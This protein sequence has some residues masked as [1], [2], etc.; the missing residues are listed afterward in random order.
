MIRYSRVSV[1]GWG[2]VVLPLISIYENDIFS[3][4]IVYEDLLAGI[5]P[6]TISTGRFRG[7]YS[8]AHGAMFCVLN[9]NSVFS[10]HKIVGHMDTLV[11]V[12]VLIDLYF[13]VPQISNLIAKLHLCIRYSMG[14]KTLLVKG[15][16][17]SVHGSAVTVLRLVQ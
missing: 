1:R 4:S 12:R 14:C 9:Y 7:R 6:I 2:S 11:L 3:R 8:H 10:L 17:V 16:D 13:S 15:T 5:E